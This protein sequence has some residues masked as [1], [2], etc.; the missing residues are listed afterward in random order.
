[1][2]NGDNVRDVSRDAVRV[3]LVV[4]GL[5]ALWSSRGVL[6]PWQVNRYTIDGILRR[7]PEGS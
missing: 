2:W 3:P 6:S 5:I 7:F 4:F 1:M